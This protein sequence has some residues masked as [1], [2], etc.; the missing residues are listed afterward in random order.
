[1]KKT[2]KKMVSVMTMAAMIMSLTAC[3]DNKTSAG[4]TSTEKA[5]ADVKGAATEAETPADT[6]VQKITVGIGNILANQFYVNEDGELTGY[7]VEVLKA[8]DEHA[9]LL[10][11]AAASTV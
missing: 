11:A 10:R 2:M 1:M 6:D 9:A 5:D 4:S 3:G 8:V 7:D